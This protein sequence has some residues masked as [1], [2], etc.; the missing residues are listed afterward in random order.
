MEVSQAAASSRR[1]EWD[2]VAVSLALADKE[3]RSC[4]FNVAAMACWGQRKPLEAGEEIKWEAQRG[5]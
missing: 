2:K 4:P 3:S 5:I 1:P